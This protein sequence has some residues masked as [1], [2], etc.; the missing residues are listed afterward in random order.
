MVPDYWNYLGRNQIPAFAYV[1]Q[2]IGI[3]FNKMFN[4]LNNKSKENK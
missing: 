4:I 1:N 3:L 2:N